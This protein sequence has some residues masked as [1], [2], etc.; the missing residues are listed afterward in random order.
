MSCFCVLLSVCPYP[1]LK[2]LSF[3]F[4]FHPFPRPLPHTTAA[5][6][7]LKSLGL[8]KSRGVIKKKKNKRGRNVG[9]IILLLSLSHGLDNTTRSSRLHDQELRDHDPELTTLRP[10]RAELSPLFSLLPCTSKC[11]SAQSINT[12]CASCIESR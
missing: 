3:T 9:N 5:A 2:E 1:C 4:T 7:R 11:P 10:S 6:Q 8:C 12:L